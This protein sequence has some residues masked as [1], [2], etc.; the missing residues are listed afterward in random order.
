VADQVRISIAEAGPSLWG[1]REAVELLDVVALGHAWLA[2]GRAGEE[3]AVAPVVLDAGEPRR[4][5]PGDGAFS[6]IGRALAGLVP[7]LEGRPIGP[8]VTVEGSERSLGDHTNEL[9]VVGESA[10]VKL[11]SRTSEGQQPAV[12]LPAHLA[13][14]GF[15]ELPSPTGSVWW[16]DALVATVS[17]YVAHASDGWEWY[18]AAVGAAAGGEIEW[19]TVDPYAVAIGSLVARLHRALATPSHVLPSPVSSVRADRVA[20]WRRG[21]EAI[22]AEAVAATDGPVG[23]RLRSIAP[24]AR[25][26]LAFL[27]EVE[28][29]PVM[30][31]HGDLHVGQILRTADGGLL[32]NDFDGN[33]VAPAGAR[34]EMQAPARDVAWMLASIDHVGRV[35]ARR[36][37]DAAGE[38]LAWIE[39]ARD[40]FLDVYREGLGERRGLLDERLLAPFAIAQEAHEFVYASRF[41]PEWCHVPDA[42]LPAALARFGA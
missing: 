7:G 12:D 6:G 10:V 8:S 19:A 39:R 2:I 22:L 25:E 3:L 15:A 13:A 29:T 21:A 1:S 24:A 4:A 40:A 23:E 14:V 34:N 11:L 42:A 36:R 27:D 16:R 38:A 18:V 5:V 35:V 30:R 26:A 28:R 9:A 32:V 20:A 17:A 31:I 33:P 41:E 37:P